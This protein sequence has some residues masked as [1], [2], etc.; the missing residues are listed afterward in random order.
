MPT[1]TIL[2]YTLRMDFNHS[3][4]R[5]RCNFHGVEFFPTGQS[6]VSCPVGHLENRVLDLE[7]KLADLAMKVFDV[8]DRIDKHEQ[9]YYNAQHPQNVHT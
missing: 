8:D 1:C 4:L 3:E 5:C 7:L 6:T 9:D 2:H